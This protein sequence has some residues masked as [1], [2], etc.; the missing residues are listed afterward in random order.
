MRHRRGTALVALAL[1]AVVAAACG[2]GSGF[3]GEQGGGD[4]EAAEGQT[5]GPAQL[6]LMVASSG[7]A[8]DKALRD[9]VA[10]YEEQSDNTV[11]LN[12][13]PEFDTTLQ[14]ALAAGD[15]PDVFF[16]TDLRLP[17]LVDAGA[18]QPAEGKIE[19][20]DDFYPSLK[21][22]FTY[23]GQFW[24]P[25]KDFSTLA[26]QYNVPM[27]EEAG[28][29][30]P[31]N[32]DELAAAAEELTTDGR[33]GLVLGAEYPRWGAFMFQAGGAVTN[34]DFT[35]MT[36]DSPEVKTALE[37]LTELHEQ[38]YAATQSELDAGWPGE[39]FGQEKAAMTIEGNWMV[40]AMNN[41]FPDVEWAVAELPAGPGGEGT[42]AFT[43]AYGVA[44]NAA[45]PDAS[46]DLVNYLVG[47][48]AML[49]YTTAFPVMPSRQ[50]LADDW[51]E[52]NPDLEPFLAGGE[53]A[54]AFQFSPGFQGAL[55]TLNSGIEGLAGGNR[56]PEE[57]QAEVDEA[58]QQS[59]GG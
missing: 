48:E 39:A 50:S 22:A 45:N 32:W 23:E 18:L 24:A 46:F 34:D 53:Y 38:G 11:Q 56:K 27:L 41:D 28:V 33:V 8:E 43:V 17:D 40:G 49:E 1:F 26:L 14:A 5:Q 31:T 2:G 54:R 36:V 10:K 6:Q 12:V 47:E 35:E 16:V 58:G 3:S 30:P 25:P 13:V 20:E 59:L 15:P 4:G 55:D 19:G 42:F 7:E 37:Y 51:L 29:E 9:I 44:A 21:D 57:V 52:A